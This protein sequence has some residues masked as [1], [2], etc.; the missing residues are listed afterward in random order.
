[1]KPLGHHAR[2]LLS[3]AEGSQAPARITPTPLLLYTQAR[4]ARP[5]RWCSRYPRQLHSHWEGHFCQ[6]HPFVKTLGT[7]SV[8]GISMTSLLEGLGGYALPAHTDPRSSLQA[9]SYSAKQ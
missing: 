8:R 4:A 1:M 2:L 9:Y 5:H 7:P 6:H 3:L